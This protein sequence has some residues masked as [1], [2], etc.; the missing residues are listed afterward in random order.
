MNT[1]ALPPVPDDDRSVFARSDPVLTAGWSTATTLSG[2]GEFRLSIAPGAPAAQARPPARAALY[3]WGVTHHADDILLVTSELIDNVTQHTAGGGELR[4][5][6]Q[7]NTI[8]IEV[9]DTDPQPPAPRAHVP[10][11]L[12]GRGLIIVAAIARRWG[13]RPTSWAGHTGKVV[14]AELVLQ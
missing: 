8:L 10:R 4:L 5:T 12:G 14:W 3:A 1:F 9:E 6:L 13:H 7:H 11:S 2:V